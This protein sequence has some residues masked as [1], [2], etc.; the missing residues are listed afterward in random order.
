MMQKNFYTL[1]RG[2]D[3]VKK[4]RDLL[5]PF[6]TSNFLALPEGSLYPL[7]AI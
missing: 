6:L 5:D 2:Y 7:Q 3:N 1:Y 4:K